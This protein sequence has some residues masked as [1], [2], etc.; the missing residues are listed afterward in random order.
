MP[1]EATRS[2]GRAQPMRS[3]CYPPY[4]GPA[5]SVKGPLPRHNTRAPRA[6]CGRGAGRTPWG[7]EN[8]LEGRTCLAGMGPCGSNL[9]RLYQNQVSVRLSRRTPPL[10][11]PSPF[12]WVRGIRDHAHPNGSTA[13]QIGPG[14][15]RSA[16]ALT[17]AAHRPATHRTTPG[18]SLMSQAVAHWSPSSSALA[19]SAHHYR[20]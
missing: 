18:Q 10:L 13:L 7:F 3:V 1:A 6:A 9:N 4:A 17:L 14:C 5:G 20:P 11:V 12:C 2:R 15:Y 16:A 19:S 8:A